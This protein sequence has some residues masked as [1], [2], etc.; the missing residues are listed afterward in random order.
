MGSGDRYFLNGRDLLI[1][2]R[3]FDRHLLGLAIHSVSETSEVNHIREE[4][5]SA[6]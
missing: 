4:L 3:K 6:I 1:D 5:L 2:S